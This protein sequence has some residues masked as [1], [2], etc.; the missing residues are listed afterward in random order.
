MKRSIIIDQ[1]RRQEL[2]YQFYYKHYGQ[3]IRK[4]R[5]ERKLTQEDL[6]SGICSNTYISKAENNQVA[7]GEEQL[8]MIM[9]KLKVTTDEFL[10]PEDLIKYLNE[11]INYFYLKDKESYKK[12]YEKIE[13]FEFQILAQVIKLGYL[14]LTENYYKAKSIYE[15]LFQYL[16]NLDDYGFTVFMIYSSFYNLGISKFTEAKYMVDSIKIKSLNNNYLEDLF[17]YLKFLVYGNLHLFVKSND[18]FSIALKCFTR[19]Y[20]VQRINELLMWHNLFLM[21]SGENKAL[22]AIDLIINSLSN[23]DKNRYLLMKAYKDSNP[24]RYIKKMETEDSE[25]Y[26]F[27]LYILARYYYKKDKKEYNELKE[28]IRNVHYKV[29]PKIDFANLLMLREKQHLM[30]LKDYLINYCLKVAKENENI[31]LVKSITDEIVSILQ[32]KNR[33]K[34]ALT[35]EL[36]TKKYISKLQKYNAE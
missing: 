10:A 34:D 23:N 21:Y 3:L 35:Y 19:A 26:L 31:Y 14:V 15:E 8:Y 22:P 18:Y 29:K 12:I 13:K 16:S 11:S 27:G 32:E 4:K 2:I 5:K 20:N 28:K 36:S 30:F 25:A 24:N 17:A 33:Y 6:A 9:E 1:K 7:I